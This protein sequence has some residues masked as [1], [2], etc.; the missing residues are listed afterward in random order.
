MRKITLLFMF[1]IVGNINA[2]TI[3]FPDANFKARLVSADVATNQ[4]ASTESIVS[5][6]NVSTYS[7]IDMNDD[8]EIQQSE[9]ALITYLYVSN[10]NIVNLSGIEYFTNLQ[11]LI[12]YGNT[13]TQLNVNSITTLKTLQCS[14]NQLTT[15][16]LLGLNNLINIYCSENFITSLDFS[17]LINLKNIDCYYNDLTALDFTGLQYLEY[18]NCSFNQITNLDFSN[19]PFFHNLE[20]AYNNLISINIKNGYLDDSPFQPLTLLWYNN[21]TLEYVCADDNEISHLQYCIEPASTASINTY[22]SFT[23]GGTYYT[24]QGNSRYDENINGCDVLDIN[25]PNFNLSFS[26]GTN[27]GSMVADDTGN[28]FFPVQAGT[29]TITPVLENPT[30]FNMSPIITS[31]TFPTVTSPYMQDFCITANGIHSDLEIVLFPIISLRAGQG[32]IYRITYKNKGTSTQSGT[33]DFTFDDAIIDFIVANPNANSIITNVISW[34]FT[35]LEPFETRSIQFALS[36]NGPTDTPSV[37]SGDIVN[38][39]TTITGT[40][41]ETPND[42]VANLNQTVVN[43][44]DPN[45]KTCVEGTTITPSM[46]GQYVHYIVRFENDGTANAQNIVVKDMIDASKFDISSLIPLSGSASFTTRITNTNQVEFIFQNINLPFDTGTNTGYIAF[47]IKTKPTLV[48]GDTFSNSANIYFDYNFPIITNTATTTIQALS[49]QD[50][51]FDN[52]FTLSPNP[53]NAI[54]NINVKQNINISLINI[55]NA[56]GQLVLTI[57]KPS[58]T[59][60][61]SNLKTGTYFIKIVSD[62]G[63]LN[64][65]FIKE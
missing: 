49:N 45:D 42:N 16:N 38:Y 54:L 29:H 56:L 34:S 5:D 27:T 10:S 60:D 43:S 55:Y 36:I 32:S 15:L 63:T 9:A 62:K 64:S 57:T 58:Y 3:N 22:C 40:I 51:Y 31:V 12:C 14:G 37:N 20:C 19:N 25:I 4:I 8:G 13:L 21:P 26:D 39:N 59:I 30:Y 24:I 2:Q 41:D 18:V 11:I 44:L 1:F 23:P 50:F 35:N 47:K 33:I 61:V 7:K 52:Y 48:V 17:G 6:W 28:Y 46:V 53:T 65:K